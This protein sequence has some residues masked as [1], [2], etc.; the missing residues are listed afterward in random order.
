MHRAFLLIFAASIL[1]A[2]ALHAPGMAYAQ[3]RVALV[4]GNGAYRNAPALLNPMNDAVDMAAAL[5]RLGFSVHKIEDTGFDAMR[6][7]LLDFGRRARAAEV[8]VVYFAGHG[9]EMGGENWLI[10]V[11]AELHSDTDVENEGIGL[12][13]VILSVSGASKL[14]LVVLDACRN[15]PFAARMRRTARLRSVDHGLGRIEPTGSVLVAY[16][17]RDGT[18][19]ADGAGRNSPFTAALLRHI[20]TPG[21]EIDFLFRYVRDDVLTATARAQEPHVYGSLSGDAVYL[22]TGSAGAAIQPPLMAPLVQPAIGAFSRARMPAPLTPENERELRPHDGFKECN[23]CP[24]MIVVPA[25]SFMMGSPVTEKDRDVDEGPQHQ[26]VFARQFAVGK[27]SVT[28][29]E[30]GACVAEGGCGGHRPWD[31]GWGRGKRPII[32]VN[33]DDAKAYV[34]WLSRKTGKDYRLLSEAEREYVTRAGTVTPF[35][36]GSSISTSQANYGDFTQGLGPQGSYRR[37]TVPVDSFDPNPWGVYQVHGNV[38]EWTED[39]GNATY[40]GAPTDGSAWT[41]GECNLRVLRGGS[42]FGGAERLRSAFRLRATIR[43]QHDRGFDTGFRV[44]RVLAR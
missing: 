6:R 11:D 39:C 19:A 5:G 24:E 21:L 4:I 14:G 23:V 44:A 31:K 38:F 9:M 1:V 42:W 32:Y 18:T 3:D 7:A 41:T 15:N 30:W 16:A 27:F 33:W 26:V 25:G 10:P 36:L 29:D 34:H 13:S 40:R 37:Q 17:A 2:T 8:A 35:W 43:R 12:K 28:F 20:E 22:R